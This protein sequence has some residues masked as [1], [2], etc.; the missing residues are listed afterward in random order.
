M[1]KVQFTLEGNAMGE[2]ALSSERVTIGRR[3]TNDIH[4]DNLAVSGTHAVIVTIGNDSFLEDLNSTNGTL[5]NNVPI[6]KHV[7]NHGDVIELGKYQL[8][9]VNERQAKSTTNTNNGFE[10]TVLMPA[11]LPAPAVVSA[12]VIASNQFN[13][14]AT[15]PMQAYVASEAPPAMPSQTAIP[16][17]SSTPDPVPSI[18]QEPPKLSPVI[19]ASPSPLIT[20]KLQVLNG[21]NAGRELILNKAM[22]TLGKPGGQVAVV[23]RRPNAYFITHVG[24]DSLPSVNGQLI[25][26]QAHALADSDVIELAGLKMKFS[27]A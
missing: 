20:A 25:G 1:A 23:T 27:L 15:A 19:S 5:V 6:K 21:T 3:P 18:N 2:Y 10:T 14:S 4:I 12:P 8:K 11:V 7:L 22:T 26:A 24:G 13:P 17:T 16:A 9:Y